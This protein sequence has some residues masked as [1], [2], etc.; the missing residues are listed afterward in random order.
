MANI[1]DKFTLH[2]RGALKNAFGLAL[3][4]GQKTVDPIHILYGISQQKGSVGAEILAK[5]KFNGLKLKPSLNKFG[6]INPNI[7][8]IDL[9]ALSRKLLEKAVLV[10]SDNKHKYIGT[11]H[12]LAA[13]F[14]ISDQ[15]LEKLFKENEIDT[16]RLTKQVKNILNSTSKFPDLTGAFES[17]RD[18]DQADQP[19]SFT[20]PADT[21]Q[22]LAFDFFAV[23]LTDRQIKKNVDPVIGREEEINRLI[24]ILSRRHKNNPI[25]LGDPGVGKTAIV[26]GLAKKIT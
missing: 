8:Q 3:S 26:E 15:H 18:H 22:P 13:I 24:Q 9:S 20:A 11:E 10:A 4:L 7:N 21:K 6:P 1:F 16:R 14:N 17:F 12:I 19:A 5:A 25:L 2:S 23:D